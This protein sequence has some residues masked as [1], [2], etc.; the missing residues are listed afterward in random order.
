MENEKDLEKQ[1]KEI[2]TPLSVA[3][4]EIWKRW[5]DK[6]LR[7]KVENFLGGEMPEVFKDSPKAVL[8]RYIA[9]PNLEFKIFNDLAKMMSLEPVFS[10]F[11]ND[12]FCTVNQDKLYMGKMTFSKKNG[13]G[14]YIVSKE[15]VIDLNK[16]DGKN[17][18]EIK[19]IWGEKFVNFHHRIFDKFYSK[20]K[21]FDAYKFKSN[22]ENPYEVYLKFF[23][24]FICNGV[25][26][27]VYYNKDKKEQSF[28]SEVILPAFNKIKN[29]FGIKPLIIPIIEPTDENV[30]LQYYPYSIKDKIKI[31]L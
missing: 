9:T 7:K 17:I 5:N 22:G 15:K 14:R 23:S 30:F 24:L 12:K 11:L 20:I 26:F 3:K 1:L 18:S 28:I 6:E 16:Y 31:N 2:Y 21:K 10:E 13:N 4:K 27:E 29:L 19:T 8:F 25:F